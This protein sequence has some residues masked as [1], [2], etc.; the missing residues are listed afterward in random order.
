MRRALAGALALLVWVG[1][2]RL[3]PPVRPVSET[4][5]PEQQETE[6]EPP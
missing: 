2:G 1:C 3:G 4:S 6:E 5:A